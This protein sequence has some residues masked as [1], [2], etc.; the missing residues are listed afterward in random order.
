MDDVRVRRMEDR[1]AE[2]AA[3][4][5]GQLGYARSAEDVRKWLRDAEAEQVA[6]VA[7]AGAEVVGW[8]EVCVERRLQNEAYALIGGLVV[9][10]DMRGQR[11]GQTL[12]EAAEEWAR[13]RGVALMRVT[14]RSTREAAHRFY[15]RDGYEV[16]KTSVVFEKRLL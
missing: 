7:E 3:E 12:C 9:R 6:L 15:L 11:I 1:D 4:L 14:S 2:A 16:V 10:E 8:V 5:A 13:E